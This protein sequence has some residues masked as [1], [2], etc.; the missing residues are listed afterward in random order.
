METGQLREGYVKE[1]NKWRKE[2]EKRTGTD[3]KGGLQLF[4]DYSSQHASPAA[5]NC[6]DF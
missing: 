6:S 2:D 5:G 1:N 3:T 4:S